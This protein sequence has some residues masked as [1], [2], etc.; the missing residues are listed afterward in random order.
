[1]HDNDQWLKVYAYVQRMAARA[2]RNDVEAAADIASECFDIFI[3]LHRDNPGNYH[4]WIG[5]TISCLKKTKERERRR[6]M[7][8][9]DDAMVF[10]R[11]MGTTHPQQDICWD[12][13]ILRHHSDKLPEQERWAFEILADGGTVKDVIEE[14][15]VGPR[16]ALALLH[17]VRIKLRDHAHICESRWSEIIADVWAQCS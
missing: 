16:E 2:Y 3:R 4:A 14:M 6:E 9:D 11:V 15:C 12:A 7:S 13:A 17:Q 1:M 5:R 8:L 10:D